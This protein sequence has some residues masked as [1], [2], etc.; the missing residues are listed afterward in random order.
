MW[1]LDPLPL[2]WCGSAEGD[3]S[4]GAIRWS[5]PS[6]AN[7]ETRRFSFEARISQESP[8][9]SL[10]VNQAEVTWA[11]GGAPLLSDDPATPQIDPTAFTILPDTQLRFTKTVRG[12]DSAATFS[13]GSLVIYTLTLQ[14]DGPGASPPQSVIDLLCPYISDDEL[15]L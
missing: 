2:E 1:L 12:T 4:D 15:I 11:E 8:V 5:L 7:D 10:V 14:N 6:L 13:P 9:G 3:V